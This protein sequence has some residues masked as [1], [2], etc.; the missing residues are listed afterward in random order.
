ML[1]TQQS[2]AIFFIVMVFIFIFLSLF[3][4]PPFTV[5]AQST[6]DTLPTFTPTPSSSPTVTPPGKVWVG[7][8]VSNTLG[9][10]EGNGSIFRVSVAGVSGLPIELQLGNQSLSALSG[11]KSEYGPYSA[12]FAP[13]TAGTWQ[14]AV[15]SLGVSRYFGSPLQSSFSATTAAPIRLP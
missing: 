13:V 8:I 4:D 2:R 12:E 10:T 9:V 5:K 15:P 6:R 14:V 11:S 1:P 7:R 3:S